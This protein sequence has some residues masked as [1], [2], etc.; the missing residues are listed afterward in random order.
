MTTPFSIYFIVKNE[1][2]RLPESLQKVVGL[3]DDLVVVDSGSTDG[4]QDIAQRFGARVVHHDWEGFARQKAFAASLCRHDWVLDLDADEILSDE[5]V[6][7]L[8]SLFEQGPP[9]DV[10]GYSMRWVFVSPQPGH[11]FVYSPDQRILRLYHRSRA[12]ITPELHSNND[13]P[14]VLQGRVVALPEQ[15]WHK[16]AMT[17]TQLESKYVKVSSDQAAYFH[18]SGRRIATWRLVL[19]LPVK[20]FKYYVLQGNYRNGW[21][22]FCVAAIAANRNFMRLAKAKEAELLDQLASRDD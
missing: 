5:L 14:Q 18:R 22:G 9:A 12:A 7:R 4:T 8:R 21:Y 16:S 6:S 10:A 20:F 17:L 19:E 11:P 3:T 2:E 15:V 1:A 13:R